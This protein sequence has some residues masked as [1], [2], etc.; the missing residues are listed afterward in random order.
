MNRP[1]KTAGASTAAGARF[2]FRPDIE[3]LRAVAILL[4]V[5]AHAGI[6]WLSGGFVGVDVFFVLSGYLISGLLLAELRT[7][8][9]IGL[10]AFYARRLRRLLP[11]LLTTIIVTSV[12]AALL[13]SPG[14]QVTQSWSAAAASVWLSNLDFALA[15]L[16][17]FGPEAGTNLFLHTWSLGVE[18]Q[19]YLLWP[20][21]ILFLAGAWRWQ[22]G[23]LSTHRLGWG[24]VAALV[25]TLA[26]SIFL[27]YTKPSWGFYLLPSRIW[28]F[29]LGALA[30]MASQRWS[31]SGALSPAAANA[32]GA[33]GMLMILGAALILDKQTPYPG[34]WAL[35][36]SLGTAA[37]LIA[38]SVAHSKLHAAIATRPFLFFGRISYAWYLWHWPVLLLGATLVS[39][40]SPTWIAGLVALSLLLAWISHHLI[41]KPLRHGLRSA[42]SSVVIAVSLLAT[43]LAVMAANAWRAEARERALTPPH[44]RL[45]AVRSDL[46]LIYQAGCDDWFHSS[47]LNLCREGEESAQRRLLIIGDSIGLQW[48]SAIAPYF[49]QQ[50]WLVLTLTKSACPMV[51]VSYFY[52]RI[53]REYV[54]CSQWREQVLAAV[55]QLKPE[56]VIAGSSS[57]YPFTA[58]QWIEGSRRVFQRLLEGGAHL[59][60]L[61]PTAGL[62]VDGPTCL[63]RQYW[64]SETGLPRPDCTR[65]LDENATEHESLSYLQAAARGLG[66]VTVSVL[67][68]NQWICPAGLCSAEIDGQIVYRDSG[69]L[70]AKFVES[71]SD[72]VIADIRR[73]ANLE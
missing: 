31:A 29:A 42:T 6:P 40:P 35:L 28:Q 52:E 50:G 1:E 69:H 12:A 44:D 49:T 17:Y 73:A 64:R 26:L 56:L 48:Y 71:I 59:V 70:S 36:P 24:I 61:G 9:T 46:P 66:G 10:A 11:L 60:V 32:A 30:L 13:L 39:K 21:F 72:R 8:G 18:E 19:F 27:T 25:L 57:S 15:R 4:V 55:A 43:A 5:G 16:D 38:G 37:L 41:E 62:G 51:D 14:E 23:K 22:G 20:A 58:S 47:T 34:L 3:G 65:L 53:G 2:E 7:T 45:I 67:D 63:S 33:F 54:E 68:P